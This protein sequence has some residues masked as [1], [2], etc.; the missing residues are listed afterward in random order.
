MVT[1]GARLLLVDDEPALL[2][3]LRR[4]LERLGYSVDACAD[5]ETAIAHVTADPAAYALVLTDLTL[6]GMNGEELLDR[7]RALNPALPA[8]LSS[9]YPHQPRSPK[10]FFLQKPYVPKVLAESIQKI[11]KR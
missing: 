10:T 7:L 3:L 2:D 9:G 5:A 1:A 4:Y 8:I 11:L 6:D